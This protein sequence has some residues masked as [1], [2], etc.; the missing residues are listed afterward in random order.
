M[1]TLL[2]LL[3]MSTSVVL[4]SCGE[5]KANATESATPTKTIQSNSVNGKILVTAI[6]VENKSSSGGMLNQCH[7]KFEVEN[8][9]RYHLGSLTIIYAP[10]L[11][12]EGSYLQGAIS[13]RDPMMYATDIKK[14]KRGEVTAKIN[15][16]K[17]ENIEELKIVNIYCGLKNSNCKS[18]IVSLNGGGL[19][20]ISQ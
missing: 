14:G 7:I 10:I 4:V 6:G 15:G 13:R 1:K 3:M 12:A 11:N 8:K 5:E 20:K 2:T 19:V 16:P 9:T 18:D 17:C